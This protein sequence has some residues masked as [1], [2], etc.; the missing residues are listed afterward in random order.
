MVCAS[1]RAL[2]ACER[3]NVPRSLKLISRI[4]QG[5]AVL[6]LTL[7]TTS[8]AEKK[9]TFLMCMTVKRNIVCHNGLHRYYIQENYALSIEI[10]YRET[11][12]TFMWTDLTTI[13]KSS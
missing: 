8:G 10:R 11:K 9:H 5:G 13:F 2:N 1:P 12:I 6:N 7:I 3:G 4:F